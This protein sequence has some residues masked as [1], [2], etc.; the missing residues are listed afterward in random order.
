MTWSKI[1]S[2]N[3]RST[4]YKYK[5]DYYKPSGDVGIFRRILVVYESDN[6]SATR[7]YEDEKLFL[8]YLVHRH[9]SNRVIIL[10]QNGPMEMWIINNDFQELVSNTEIPNIEENL[11]SYLSKL[12]FL[13]KM[14]PKGSITP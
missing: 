6:L 11:D 8:K 13:N 3:I 7:A 5:S 12:F 4:R 1:S 10:R 14:R 2:W 9:G